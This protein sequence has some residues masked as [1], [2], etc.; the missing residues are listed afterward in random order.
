MKPIKP[1]IINSAL[2][3]HIGLSVKAEDV[4]RY[5]ELFVDPNILDAVWN[6][7]KQVVFGRRGSGKTALLGTITE[8]PVVAAPDGS[9]ILAF[10]FSAQDFLTSPDIDENLP[11]DKAKVFAFFQN[12][13]TQLADRLTRSVELVLDTPRFIDVFMRLGKGKRSEIETKTIEI[14]ELVSKGE[15]FWYPSGVWSVKE[16]SE[17]TQVR[18]HSVDAAATASLSGEGGIAF[19]GGKVTGGKKRQARSSATRVLQ[20]DGHMTVRISSVRKRLLE[21]IDLLGLDYLLIAIDEWMVL[22]P[23]VQ[24]DIQPEFAE[25]LKRF[26]F[27]SDKIAVKIATNWYQTKFFNPLTYHGLEIDADIYA[28]ANLDW[29][30]LSEE[31]LKSFYASLLYKRLKLCDD[32]ISFYE[33]PRDPC[34]PTHALTDSIFK[35]ERA[36]LELVHGAQ[37][38]PRNFIL[39]FRD[40]TLKIGF[41]ITRKQMDFELVRNCIRTKSVTG[42][43]RDVVNETPGEAFLWKYV[44]PAVE[45]SGTELF[46]VRKEEIDEKVRGAMEELVR[47]RLIYDYPELNLPTEVRQHYKSYVLDYG[48]F[49]DWERSIQYSNPELRDRDLANARITPTIQPGESIDKYVI[50]LQR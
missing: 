48:T 45:Q 21:I 13:V 11:A 49:L 7:Q 37:G 4:K 28:V 2:R 42:R 15:R 10:W 36:F 23:S 9:K 46:L 41:D 47:A 1:E 27:G 30:L 17:V 24:T 6:N 43:L 18:E 35:D 8:T 19:I 44:K 3:K 29:S 26:L 12:F 34:R 14:L 33:D 16:E 39:A 38:L 20:A 32:R 22:D 5:S 50:R 25:L 40:A 31:E